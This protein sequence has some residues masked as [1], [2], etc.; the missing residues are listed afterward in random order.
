[1]PRSLAPPGQGTRKRHHRKRQTLN[2]ELHIDA[3]PVNI[4]FD[5][6]TRVGDREHRLGSVHKER[7]GSTN[8][9]LGTSIDWPALEFCDVILRSN[10]DILRRSVDLSSAW[11]G[12]LVYRNLP[13]EHVKPASAP[14]S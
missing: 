2:V 1:M 14:A 7:G 5:V 13:I 12:E 3:V 9:S 6:V 11:K 10:A 4:A 8:W